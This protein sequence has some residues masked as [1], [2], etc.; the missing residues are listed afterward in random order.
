MH[1]RGASE[2]A[3]LSKIKR[4]LVCIIAF[5]CDVFSAMQQDHCSGSS[6]HSTRTLSVIFEARFGCFR[7]I[8]KSVT[9]I[10]YDQNDEGEFSNFLNRGS[11]V[12]FFDCT[13]SGVIQSLC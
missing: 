9:I 7:L 5:A 8:K 11:L 3:R 13:R 10:M 4:I 2:A 6:A 12:V 1:A